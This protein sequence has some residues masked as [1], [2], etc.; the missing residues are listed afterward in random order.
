MTERWFA[1]VP[2]ARLRVVRSVTA[3]YAAVWL[4]VRAGYAWD[5]AGLPARRFQPVGV[6]TVL[7][8]PPG[9]AAVAA[10]WAITVV[11]A[12]AVAAGSRVRLAAP[13]LAAGML[14][15]ATLTSS[16]GQVFHTENLLVLHLLVLAAASLLEPDRAGSDPSGWPL[17]LMM[18]LV[19]TAYVVAGVAKLRHGGVDWATGDVLRSHVAAD[20]L[21]KLL[22][23]DPYSPLGGWLTGLPWIW[24]PIGV[25]TLAVELGAPVALVGGRIRAAWLAT[26]WS[27]HVGVFVLMAISFPY[28][29]SGVAYLAFVPAERVAAAIRQR[30]RNVRRT[31][32]GRG[33]VPGPTRPAPSPGR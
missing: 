1:P 22:L 32:T 12:L 6:L 29:L 23:D 7:D 13:V 28:Q 17:R 10:V 19:V 9:R 5:V 20:N 21:R 33:P 14:S 26:A 16:Y 3:G 4:V 2:G 18:V 11:A 24:P 15:I 25:L 27:F 30:W 31:R 8:A